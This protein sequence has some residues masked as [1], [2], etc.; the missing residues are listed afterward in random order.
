MTAVCIYEASQHPREC[1]GMIEGEVTRDHERSKMM[2]RLL[3]MK[4]SIQNSTYTFS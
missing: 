1:K 2:G 4:R 3:K